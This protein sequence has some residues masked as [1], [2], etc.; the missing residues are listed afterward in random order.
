M[1]W[2]KSFD[3]QIRKVTPT[4]ADLHAIN[5]G[6][7]SVEPVTAEDIYCGTMALCN[8]QYDRSFERFPM[9]YL[10]R[11]ADTM[12]GKSVMTGHD[13]RTLPVGRFY[14]SEIHKSA[15]DRLDL[16]TSYYMMGDDPL[17]P[18]I[19][20]GIIKH[21][22]IGFEPDKRICDI[23]GK[24]Y[25]GWWYASDDE[26]DDVCYHIAGRSYKVDGK[27]VVA[28]VTYGGDESKVEG[29][30]GSFV[31]LGC[32]HGAEV[33]GQNSTLSHAAKGAHF[34]KDKGIYAVNGGR[35]VG[36]KP[37]KEKGMT[38]EEKAAA[39]KEK[40]KDAAQLAKEARLIAAGEAYIKYLCGRIETRYAGLNLEST[41]KSLAAS[42]ADAPIENIEAAEKEAAKL[43]DERFPPSGKGVPESTG[44]ANANRADAP[45]RYRVEGMM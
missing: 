35:L 8:N 36:E 18:K 7:M 43:F 11:F 9:E 29:V 27:E 20:A 45:Y 33:V 1:L 28:T 37:P 19:K 40:L 14:D 39:D 34:A 26:E 32:Q 30:E 17:V 22:S 10:K 15:G 23:D 6:G 25:D 24:D 4:A 12:P 21:V 16:Y 44:D 41:G 5:T 2:R 3:V 13:Y 31:W 38:P 42:L